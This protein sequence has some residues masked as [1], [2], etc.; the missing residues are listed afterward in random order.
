LAERP[1]W[2]DVRHDTNQQTRITGK[3]AHCVAH[4]LRGDGR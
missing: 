2:L 1:A 3:A 4:A